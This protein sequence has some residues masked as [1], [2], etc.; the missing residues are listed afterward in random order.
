MTKDKVFRGLLLF[1]ALGAFFF[2]MARLDMRPMHNDEANQAVKFSALLEEGRYRYDPEDHHGPSLYYLSLPVVRSFSG[3]DIARVEES[4]LRSVPVLFGA[5][6]I[7]LLLLLSGAGSKR[8]MVISG[9]LMA[10]SPVMVYYS[11]F[12]IQEILLVFFILAVFAAGWR[13]ACTRSWIW[14]AAAGLFTGMMIVTKETWV[15]VLFCIVGA[16]LL[17]INLRRTSFQFQHVLIF[18]GAAGLVWLLFFS[19]F[20][21]HPSGPLDSLL[22]FK[23][24]FSR[25]GDAGFHSHPWYYYL[26]MLAYA[27]YGSGPVWSEAFILL[28]A[29]LGGGAIFFSRSVRCA[30][31]GFPRFVL[32]YTLLS[33]GIYSVIPY[34]TP[35]NMLPFYL[36]I[37]LLA[38][39]GADYILKLI[40]TRLLRTA[41]IL[42]LAAGL[43]WLGSQSYLASFKYY[44]DPVNPYVYAH[45]STDFMNLVHR[46]EQLQAHHPEGR[47]M[48]IKVITGPYETWP[49]PWYLRK[50]KQVGYWQDSAAA[51]KLDNVP[52]IISSGENTAALPEQIVDNYISE[53]YGLRPEILLTINIHPQLWEAFLSQK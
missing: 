49:L 36:G 22:A 40:Q 27:K 21:S 51:G 45:T 10:L 41:G 37:I 17:C 3:S 14:A 48:L 43:F 13:Y 11:R 52:V 5:A 9:L 25:A 38:G 8:S 34:K 6:S 53:F 32:F 35:W 42:V 26:Q 31:S 50:F 23:T 24:Y 4:L 29:V 2:R 1:I 44:A 19:S 7:L 46:V 18:M 39:L 28:L 20:L 33:V 15:I 12:Y 47:N 30:Y 16:L